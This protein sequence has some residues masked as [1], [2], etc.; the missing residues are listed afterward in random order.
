M[1]G[2]ALKTLKEIGRL[3]RRPDV[4][5]LH[6]TT[7][8]LDRGFSWL[9]T[10]RW[11]ACC[12]LFVVIW[13]VSNRLDVLTDPFP[14]YTIG[15]L[16]TLYNAVFWLVSRKSAKLSEEW[17]LRFLF[18]QITV[19]LVF[20]T[21]LLYYSGISHNPFIFYFVFHIIIAGILLPKS[22][23]YLEA[24]LDSTMVGTVLALQFWGFIPEHNLN[25]PYS[26][27][28]AEGKV[29][30]LLGRFFALSSAL[31]FAVYFTVSVLRNVRY[32][33]AELR[34]KEKLLS[35]GLLVSGILHQIKNPL[36]G[37]KNCLHHIHNG[38]SAPESEKFVA[39]MGNE[40]ERIEHFTLRLQDYA[41]PHGIEIQAVDVNR[42]IAAS[43]KL[44]EIKDTGEVKIRLLLG[45]IPKAKA[46]PFAVQEVV[47]NLCTNAVSAMPDGGTLTIRTF[48][49][50]SKPYSSVPGVG[51]EIS[52]TGK[53]ISPEKIHLVFEPFYSTKSPREGTGLG[54]WIC[55]MLVNQMGGLIELTSTPGKGS[56]FKVVLAAV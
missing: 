49:A 53:G 28:D 7:R 55:R 5:V 34:Q 22:Y 54:L 51:I 46:D 45:R 33:E 29:V 24:V 13:F 3:S 31:L 44:L 39:L 41:R 11:A 27:G 30:F 47:I 9:V 32:A 43:L 4:R 25:F 12:G 40:L 17:L 38:S 52:D 16:L 15:L 48:P 14:L 42:E 56:T 8:Y 21:L 18:L 36:D 23:A 35:L 26:G 50:L 37:L 20:L 19:D 2:E 10:L 1:R 6:N